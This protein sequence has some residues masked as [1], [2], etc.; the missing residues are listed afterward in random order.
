MK[1]FLSN[2]CGSSRSGFAR[3]RNS[4][5]LFGAVVATMGG[6]MVV[7]SDSVAQNRAFV[8]IERQRNL[9]IRGQS[10]AKVRSQYGE[11]ASATPAV[12]DPPISR[13]IYPGFTVYFEYSHV[14]TTV[15]EEDSLP[16]SLENIQ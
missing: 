10:Q 1:R 12:G 4:A 14:I 13:W 3:M 11:P 8:E 2:L 6:T 7:P 9:P 15:A 5:L 16:S